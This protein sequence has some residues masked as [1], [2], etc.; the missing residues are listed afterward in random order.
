MSTSL[1]EHGDQPSDI[2]IS[3]WAIRVGTGHRGDTP[4]TDAQSAGVP[5]ADMQIGRVQ[6]GALWVELEELE[7]DLTRIFVKRRCQIVALG[8]LKRDLH[9]ARGEALSDGTLTDELIVQAIGALSEKM[10]AYPRMG[11]LLHVPGCG[12]VLWH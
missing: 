1:P 2:S 12:Y 4:T 5:R 7:E 10:R 6:A 8:T 11:R 9:A 3:G